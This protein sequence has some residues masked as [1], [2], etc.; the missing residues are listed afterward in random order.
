M[1]LVII[2]KVAHM[3]KF[4][5]KFK[6]VIDGLLDEHFEKAFFGIACVSIVSL[7]VGSFT[8][9]T[10]GW[11]S[12]GSDL[13]RFT[14]TALIALLA[15]RM[16]LNNMNKN[17]RRKREREEYH[18]YN[19][20]QTSLGQLLFSVRT[21]QKMV[22]ETGVNEQTTFDRATRI[23][24]VPLSMFNHD[25][26]AMN[27]FHYLSRA[28]KKVDESEKSKLLDLDA[29][30]LNELFSNFE[31]LKWLFE[32]HHQ[33]MHQPELKQYI[34]SHY[35]GNSSY[36]ITW[37]EIKEVIPFSEF[38]AMLTNGEGILSQL[39]SLDDRLLR[40]LQAL[41]ANCRSIISEDAINEDMGIPFGMSPP[42]R[43]FDVYTL[44]PT[45]T[46][47]LNAVDYPS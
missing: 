39:R 23:P 36:Q 46:D 40:T 6:D 28:A 11:N 7:W 43:E 21:L 31:Q 5:K 26:I 15:A 22:K 45:E 25:K 33:Y 3:D 24:E 14:S 1:R 38:S 16:A 27:Q 29:L 42:P 41:H 4:K 13:A 34:A 8:A 18:A 30:N 19:A 47:K 17:E 9:V 37:S 32:R 44:P 20:L 10:S 35:L 12:L 2:T